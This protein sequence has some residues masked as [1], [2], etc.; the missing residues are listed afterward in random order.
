MAPPTRVVM[1]RTSHNVTQ[2]GSRRQA[3]SFRDEDYRRAA[4][5]LAGRN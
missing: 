4:L 1:E 3:V 2:R 5:A